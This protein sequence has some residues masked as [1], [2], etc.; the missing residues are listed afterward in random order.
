MFG[1]KKKVKIPPMLDWKA[2]MGMYGRFADDYA[3]LRTK[4]LSELSKEERKDLHRRDY[5]NDEY[6]GFCKHPRLK[7]YADLKWA[8]IF[9]EDDKDTQGDTENEKDLTLI[10]KYKTLLGY[11]EL[12]NE[13]VLKRIEKVVD[14][15]VKNKTF[16]PNTFIQTDLTVLLDIPSEYEKRDL[17]IKKR[18]LINDDFKKRSQVAR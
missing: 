17:A 11:S 5:F 1:L 3:E 6:T 16:V 12:S 9:Y 7:P 10:T 14:G 2:E 18:L 13:E 8:I 4:P 15:A